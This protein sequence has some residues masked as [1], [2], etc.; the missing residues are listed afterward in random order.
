MEWNCDTCK[1]CSI[2][3]GIIKIY[4][5]KD[6]KLVKIKKEC[7]CGKEVSEVNVNVNNTSLIMGN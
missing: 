5:Y 6:G 4:I 1:F 3:Q 7:L 2:N